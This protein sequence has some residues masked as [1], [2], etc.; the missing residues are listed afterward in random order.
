MCWRRFFSTAWRGRLAG[1]RRLAAG[2]GLPGCGGGGGG[3]VFSAGRAAAPGHGAGD[4]RDSGQRVRLDGY[5]LLCR[6]GGAVRAVAGGGAADSLAENRIRAG[7]RE[8]GRFSRSFLFLWLVQ[9]R[10][11][12]P[13]ATL[14]AGGFLRHYKRGRSKPSPLAYCGV[15][16]S[17]R[18]SCS[19]C[20]VAVSSKVITDTPLMVSG[21]KSMFMGKRI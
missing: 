15:M 13:K 4:S 3:P 18:K 9:S 8:G 11:G 5:S 19:F 7:L 10:T 20:L 16:S 12:R 1:G 14:S 2:G 6:R 17:K 21:I